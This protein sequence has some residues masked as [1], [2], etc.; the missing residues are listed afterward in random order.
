MDL[1]ETMHLEKKFFKEYKFNS[2]DPIEFASKIR[3]IIGIDLKEQKKWLW[4]ERGNKDF[5]HYRFLNECKETLNKL[6]ILVFESE[7][8][9]LEEMKGL[10]LYY[11]EYPII[12]LNGSDFVNSRI[13]SLFHELVHLMLGESAICDLEEDNK[14]EVFCNAVAGEFL[15]PSQDLL[16]KEEFEPL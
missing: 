11:D 14:K 4:D 3:E 10:T 2:K 7:R 12:V 8:V 16:Q 5:Q 13:F 6:G 9:S 1:L 15:V